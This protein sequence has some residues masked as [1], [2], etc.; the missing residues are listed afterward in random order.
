MIRRI[1][2]RD[3]HEVPFDESKITTA[4]MKAAKAVDHQNPMEVGQEITRQI[5][6]L[7]EIF[8]K[9]EGVPTVEQV[10]DLVEKILIEKGYASIAKAYILYRE[11]HA[12]MRDTKKLLGS[13]ADMINKYLEKLDWKVNENSNMSYSL[14]GLNNYIASELTAQYWLQEIYSPRVRERHIS[15]DLHIHDLS[16]LSV[17]C[18]GWDLYDLLVSGFTGVQTKMSSKPAKHFRSLLGQIVNFFYTMQGESAGAQAFS[19]F[20]TYLAPFIYYDDLTYRDVKQALQEF[21][22]NL[23]VPTRVGFQTPFTN[24]TMDL[25]PPKILEGLPA[26]VGGK[27]MDKAYGEFQKEMDMLNRAFAEVMLE[28]DAT[29]KVFPFP[30]P[31]YNIT[32][33]F[34]WDNDVLNTV[35]DMTARYGIPYFSN[36]VNSDM[37]PDD[38]RSMCCRLRLDNRELRKRGGGLFGSNP[39]TGSIGVVTLNMPRTGYLSKNEDDFIERTFELM[40]IAKESLEIKRKV[41][42]RLTEANLYPYSKFYLRSIKEETGTYWNNHFNTVGINGMN[43]ALL[44]FMGKTIADPEGM[45]FATR[46]MTAMRQR[47]S[48]FQEETG[49]LYNLEATPAEGTSYRFARLDKERYGNSIYAANEENVRQLGADPYYTN[50]SQ[51]PV[52]YTDDIFEALELQDKLQTLYTGGTVFHG[53]LGESM[54]SGES[55][56]RLVKRIAENFHLPYFTITP[57]FSVCPI[58]GYIPGAHEYCPYCDAEKGYMEEVKSL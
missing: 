57:T 27:A 14:Q 32:R 15:G 4:V 53:F 58:H 6:S 30:I 17:Y 11:Q 55:T 33:D 21:I 40:D 54:P 26:I 48:D 39:M 10:Q 13:A 34:H 42:E 43:E 20:D 23:N 16:N 56:K 47:L 38:A 51:L 8:Y 49:N 2:K 18:C 46:V 45:F 22:F 41:L 50:S 36:F 3:G 1:R 19:N 5:V 25:I 29:G 9:E 12:K 28:G 24:I 52:G 37:S 35:W 44:N 31:T 7:L